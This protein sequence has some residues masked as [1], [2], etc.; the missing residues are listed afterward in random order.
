MSG[1]RLTNRLEKEWKSKQNEVPVLLFI[2][3]FKR[4]KN[5]FGNSLSFKILNF[6]KPNSPV[7][8][9]TKEIFAIKWPNWTKTQT[10]D[11][12]SHT[13]LFGNW[14]L[15]FIIFFNL[16]LR[17]FMI[18][19]RLGFFM[20]LR[21]AFV[22]FFLQS[23]ASHRLLDNYD[24]LRRRWRLRRRQFSQLNLAAITCFYS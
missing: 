4:Y 8:P 15:D 17:L 1:T 10:Y 3:G 11:K 9:M 20:C 24:G 14:F 21:L 7:T 23:N 6:S 13:L 2:W 22:R 12:N 16:F 19:L 18:F 5:V